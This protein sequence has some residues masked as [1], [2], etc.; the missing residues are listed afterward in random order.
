MAVRRTI[1]CTMARRVTLDIS[2][3]TTRTAPRTTTWFHDRSLRWTDTPSRSCPRYN[4]WHL[5]TAMWILF[6]LLLG[7]VQAAIP[8][9]PHETALHKVT[10]LWHCARVPFGL[11]PRARHT[12]Y[13]PRFSWTDHLQWTLHRDTNLTPKEL[14]PKL[15]WCLQHLKLS[16]PLS[17]FQDAVIQDIRDL[18]DD[19]Q[20]ETTDWFHSLPR[21]VQ[22]AY[23]H[24][25]IPVLIHLLRLLNYPQTETYAESYR[26][27]SR[28][29]GN[30]LQE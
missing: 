14:D 8:A 25:Q 22:S 5:P 12:E 15:K 28:S 11:P 1:S 13:M 19:M 26:M 30:S 29:W 10:N 16:Q 2:G 6:L 9:R 21:R 4:A 3:G 20:E 17:R 23:Q 18:V 7:S 27:D 24:K